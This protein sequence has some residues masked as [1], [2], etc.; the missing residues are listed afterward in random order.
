MKFVLQVSPMYVAKCLGHLEVWRSEPLEA[1]G[2]AMTELEPSEDSEV[3]S[4][5]TLPLRLSPRVHRR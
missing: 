1:S 4:S 5:P 2:G 3:C